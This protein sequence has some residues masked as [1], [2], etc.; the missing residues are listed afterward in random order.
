MCG[1][2]TDS[3]PCADARVARGQRAD[4]GLSLFLLPCARSGRTS[5]LTGC[6]GDVGHAGC[7]PRTSRSTSADISSC[8]R[9][10]SSCCSIA[11]NRCHSVVWRCPCLTASR[12][13][14]S[15]A[16]STFRL[17]FSMICL[18]ACFVGSIA[19]APEVPAAP[20]RN[21]AIRRNPTAVSLRSARRTRGRRVEPSPRLAAWPPGLRPR[22][23][24][25]V[26]SIVSGGL[27][28]FYD[29]RAA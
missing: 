14:R 25:A 20:C 13:A 26:S 4:E 17:N 18:A 9:W 27:L 16:S 22:T 23:A 12:P 21:C 3:P 6:E 28:D 29:R 7:T 11:A 5:R 19:R 15:T 1:T 8:L 24:R 2:E 10:V